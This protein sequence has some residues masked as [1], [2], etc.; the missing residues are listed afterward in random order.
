MNPPISTAAVMT[1]GQ[2]H[3]TVEGAQGIPAFLSNT[4][5]ELTLHMHGQLDLCFEGA[6]SQL[7]KEKEDVSK[8]D[9]TSTVRGWG[10]ETLLDYAVAPSIDAHECG[11]ADDIDV[12]R[13]RAENAEV[14]SMLTPLLEIRVL[15]ADEGND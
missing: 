8:D 6:A 15:C 1:P 13:S 10:L 11:Y 9:S 4:S 5:V 7:G 14:Q 3:I 2:L 12:G